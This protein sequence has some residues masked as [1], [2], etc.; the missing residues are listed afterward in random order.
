LRKTVVPRSRSEPMMRRTPDARRI[1]GGSGLVED[2]E[3]RPT[4]QSDGNPEALLHALGEDPGSPVGSIDQADNS[5]AAGSPGPIRRA[6]VEPARSAV[7]TSRAVIQ[8][9]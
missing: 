1:E 4:E 7:Q 8:P 6:A 3:I 5:R 9:W 2:Y